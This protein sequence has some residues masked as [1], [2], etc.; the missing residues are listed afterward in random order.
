MDF[1]KTLVPWMGKTTKM[2]GCY[3]NE[4]LLE[5]GIDLTREQ[6]IILAKLHQKDGLMQNELAFVTERD[7]TSLTRLINTME[8]KNLLLREKSKIDKRINKIYLTNS[9]RMVYKNAAPV[10]QQTIKNLQKG[11]GEKE[12][13][14]TIQTLQK[15]QTNLTKLSAQYGINQS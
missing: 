8:R 13:Q 5:N 7:K 10:I 6:W 9:G 12:I 3:I 15:I 1:H 4:V 2:I 11:L 14:N